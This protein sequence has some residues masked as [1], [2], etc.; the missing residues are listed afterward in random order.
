MLICGITGA[1][2]V[3]GKAI[4][5]E[6]NYKFICFKGRIENKKQINQWIK[7]NNFD[8]IIHLAAIVPTSIVNSNFGKAKRVN[9]NG[10]K[11]IV[12]AIIKNKP[13]LKWFFFSSTSHVYK[14][15]KKFI[16][17]N[18]KSNTFPNSKYGLT[19]IKAENYIVSQFKKT[20]INFCIGR[21]FSYSSVDQKPPFLIPSLIKKISNTKSNNIIF[22]K[23][24]YYRDFISLRGIAKAINFLR[25]KKSQGIYNIGSGKSILLEDIAKYLCVKF[26]KN[27]SFKKN[28][29][30]FII[31]N[32]NKLNKLGFF[33]NYNFYKDLDKILDKT[34]C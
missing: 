33:Y 26:K 11:N 12:D 19:K 10:T 29:K 16:L 21:I 31:A 13:N 14:A 23:L 1:S 4:R 20:N 22:E 34:R 18:E 24:N 3:L 32:I 25:K 17:I 9:F 28:K 5:K 2:G 27:Y 6:L 30:N 7:N 8:L 15:T